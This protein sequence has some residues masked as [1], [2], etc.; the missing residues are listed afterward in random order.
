MLKDVD[1]RGAGPADLLDLDDVKQVGGVGRTELELRGVLVKASFARQSG[2]QD[3]VL[4]LAAPTVPA[5]PE[6]AV[7][8]PVTGA[9][10]GERPLS[11]T[12]PSDLLS[13]SRDYRQILE[14]S[15]KS[16]AFSDPT[17]TASRHAA[18]VGLASALA[19]SG[20]SPRDV[21]ELHVAAVTT[22][23]GESGPRRA[24]ALESEGT[25]LVLEVM[26]HL[27]AAYRL[28]ALRPERDGA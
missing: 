26:G 7:R 12:A 24:R 6:P 14:Q 20:A 25:I 9:I 17:L 18:V 4:V 19:S 15:L 11:E 16:R 5:A 1:E 21:I 2:R 13:L 27:A 22:A 3:R 8:L 23:I 10:Y 28:R